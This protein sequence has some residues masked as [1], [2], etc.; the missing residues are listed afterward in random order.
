MGLGLNWYQI[1]NKKC[2]IAK[3][4]QFYIGDRGSVSMSAGLKKPSLA[5]KCVF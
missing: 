2:Y 3:V 4:V 1:G 5:C